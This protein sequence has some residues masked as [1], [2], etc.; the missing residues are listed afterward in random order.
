MVTLCGM[1]DCLPQEKV[2]GAERGPGT[3]L[4]GEA[5]IDIGELREVLPMYLV[6]TPPLRTLNNKKIFENLF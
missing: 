1:G 4:E 3:R 6:P 5:R 2:A